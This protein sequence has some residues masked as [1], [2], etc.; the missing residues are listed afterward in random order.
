MRP[1]DKEVRR[2]DQASTCPRIPAPPAPKPLQAPLSQRWRRPP[3]LPPPPS[4]RRRP[5]LRLPRPPPPP[6]SAL[7]PPQPSLRPWERPPWCAASLRL[8][9]LW[10]HPLRLCLQPQR[11]CWRPLRRQPQSSP[12]PLRLRP[13]RPPRRACTRLPLPR[14]GW[15]RWARGAGASE[16]ARRPWAV[17]PARALQRRQ[18]G[19][20]VWL[21]GGR[22]TG[23]AAVRR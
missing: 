13:W 19:G 21:G 10:P 2:M 18:V 11:R 17:R 16:R 20:R 6:P 7:Q 15:S 3:R 22:S 9:S 4:C 23:C 14:R 8:P 5:W 1:A 12:P